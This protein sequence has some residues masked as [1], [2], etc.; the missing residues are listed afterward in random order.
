MTAAAGASIPVWLLDV[1]GVINAIT[2][3]P[4]EEVWPAE[5]WTR[6]FVATLDGR[7]W[8][9]LTAAPVLAYLV[10]AHEAGR[11]EI[12]WHTTWQRSAIERL[13]PALG[14]PQWPLAPAPEF[15]SFEDSGYA[16]G[17]SAHSWW[18]TGA[19]QRVRTEESRRLLWTDDDLSA[20]RGLPDVERLQSDPDVCLVSPVPSAG[21]SRPDLA[22]IERFLAERTG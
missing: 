20:G 21:L 1:D 22:R 8:P 17:A 6:R 2:G 18:K 3:R 4:D 12:R 13:A 5:A 9:I 19:A 14:L 7:R 10:D 16:R 11:V 15:T